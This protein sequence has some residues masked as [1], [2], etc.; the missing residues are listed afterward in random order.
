[1]SG[2]PRSKA[3]REQGLAALCGFI[4]TIRTTVSDLAEATS[5]ALGEVESM[6]NSKLDITDN[7]AF[8]IPITGWGT[9]TSVS[10]YPNYIDVTVS[11]LLA[12]DTVSVDVAPG[13][14]SIARAADFTTVQS[15][16]GKFRLRAKAIPSKAIEAEYHV[17]NTKPY[18]EEA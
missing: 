9:D 12:T 11:G 15:Y 14:A 18:T 2:T 5:T 16:A 8:T 7:V 10:D 1:M 17:T 3:L 13:S 4:K 6:L